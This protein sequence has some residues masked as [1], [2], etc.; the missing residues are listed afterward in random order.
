MMWGMVF[1]FADLRL[2]LSAVR[3]LTGALAG[4]RLACR[5]STSNM[6]WSTLLPP[7]LLGWALPLKLPMLGL[8]L[9]LEALAPCWGSRRAFAPWTAVSVDAGSV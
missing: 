3:D 1:S 5:P 9:L 6:P 8:E 2:R 7:L 4:S